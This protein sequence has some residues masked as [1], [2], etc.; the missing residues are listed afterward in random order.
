MAP[1]LADS[2]KRDADICADQVLSLSAFSCLCVC[3]APPAVFLI[4]ISTT[5][6]RLTITCITVL[7]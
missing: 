4:V 3:S 2:S 7:Q 1:A 5:F 6:A